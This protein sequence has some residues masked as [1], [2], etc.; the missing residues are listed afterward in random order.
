MSS[1][2]RHIVAWSLYD[3]ANS[4][5]GTLVLTFV[6][7]AYFTK[8]IADDP[9]QGTSL[10]ARAVTLSALVVALSS[11][12][13]GAVA[14]LRGLRKPF[15]LVCTVVCVAA[16]A[17]LYLPL[18]G[19]ILL[20]LTIFCV[21]NT[22][23]ELGIVFYNA[24]LP[25]L[26]S[27]SNIGRISGWSWGLGYMGGVFCTL[28]ALVGFV[29]TD[30]PWFGFVKQVGENIRATNLL[31]AAWFAVFAAPLFL[32]VKNPPPARS[33]TSAT[34]RYRA[35]LE[36][37]R[38][39]KERPQTIRFLVARLIYNDGL[40]TVFA[41]AG[42]YAAGT[43]NFTFDEIMIFGLA[44]NL[45]AGLGAFA[46]GYLDDV[47]GGKRTV[48]CTLA[49]FL[50]GTGIVAISGH[51]LGFWV[52]G[53]MISTF[54]GP[55]QSASR[56]LLGRFLPRKRA[57]EFY[58]LF[59]FSGKVTAFIGPLLLGELTRIFQSQRIGVASVAFFFLVGG[60]LL[61]RVNEADGT[62]ESTRT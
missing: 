14:D 3:F 7:S 42:I 37:A 45:S 9:H 13:L 61:T 35:L 1:K 4:S 58:G 6:Y 24:Y 12:V 54:A 2:R 23:Y 41:F 8:A 38:R 56:S 48:L 16:T 57:N 11:P 59:A 46:M 44:A 29:S 39:L 40:V 36:S 27:E 10:W 19:Q 20:A 62:L 32:S 31:V 43:F 34:G 55:N 50:V 5:F 25:D 51:K 15:L 17:C 49:V 21:A 26:T 22:A 47:W 60:L 30:A 52:G 28:V 53:L 18:P 33:P